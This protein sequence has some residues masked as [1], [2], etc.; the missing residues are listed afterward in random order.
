MEETAYPDRLFET[1]GLC[2]LFAVVVVV[3]VFVVVVVVVVV[4]T[5]YGRD[6]LP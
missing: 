2:V 5:L 1:E 6:G 4:E 3:V